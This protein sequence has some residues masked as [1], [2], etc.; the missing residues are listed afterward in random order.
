LNWLSRKLTSPQAPQSI[1]L[2]P[3]PPG[4]IS[5]RM[6]EEEESFTKKVA[7]QVGEYVFSMV[8][9]VAILC[10]VAP[11][12]SLSYI[13]DN[14]QDKVSSITEFDPTVLW[15][16]TSDLVDK[17]IPILKMEGDALASAFDQAD[18]YF[19]AVYASP[20]LENINWKYALIALAVLTLVGFLFPWRK[21]VD[22]AAKSVWRTIVLVLGVL[23]LD[24]GLTTLSDKETGTYDICIVTGAV[25]LTFAINSVALWG[26]WWVLR[27]LG[28]L[29]LSAL[30]LACRRVLLTLGGWLVRVLGKVLVVWRGVR[31][32][33]RR[34]KVVDGSE[35]ME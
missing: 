13:I 31:R 18:D 30:A 12:K 11:Q 28:L 5:A 15:N 2:A 34:G 20:W 6:P 21:L 1:Y 24:D 27:Q 32:R 35:K 9:P 23:P 10:Y 19:F 3:T 7:S 8:V 14:A 4:N 29:L 16:A 22:W 25:L 17:T 26:L 33:L